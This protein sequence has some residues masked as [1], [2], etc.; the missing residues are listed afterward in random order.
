MGHEG[1]VLPI[2]Y[3]EFPKVFAYASVVK[4][5][6]NQGISHFFVDLEHSMQLNELF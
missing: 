5:E 6:N 3:R 4:A 1:K 2:R